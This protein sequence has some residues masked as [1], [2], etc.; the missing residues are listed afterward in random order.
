VVVSRRGS[1]DRYYLLKLLGFGVFLHRIHHDDPPGTFH[2]HPWP[3]VSFILGTYV[4]ERLR[5]EPRRRRFVN[6]LSSKTPHRVTL[7][8]GP[9]WT[10]LVHGRRDNEWCVLDDEGR[11]TSREP[12]RGTS[13]PERKSYT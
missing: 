7:P 10:L 3:W 11:P 6:V 1:V 12:W 5:E 13:N 2:T 8:A 4:E 9:V